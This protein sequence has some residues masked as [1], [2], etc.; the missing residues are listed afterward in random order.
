MTPEQQ[1]I[2][3]IGQ[4]LASGQ[5]ENRA[6]LAD[7]A[8]QFAEVCRSACERLMR[9]SDYLDKGRRSEAAYE[10]R[11][12]P[13]LL[14]L[15][16]LLTSPALKKWH[17]V[18]VDL[19]LT[20]YQLPDAEAIGRLRR[21]CEAEAA[22]EP[23]LREYR[24]LVH[25]SDHAGCIEVLRRIREKDPDNPSW[26]E[27]LRP[28]EEEELPFWVERAERGLAAMD[29]VE[30]KEVFGKLNHPMRV[31]SPPDELMARLRRALL[32]ERAGDLGAEGERTLAAL[33]EAMAAEDV[34]ALERLWAKAAELEADEAFLHR[35]EGWSQALS[36]SHA[37][38]ERLARRR[39][40]QAEF[41]QALSAF[42][43]LLM[44]ESTGLLE[45]RH[46]YERL[47][48]WDIPLPPELPRQ[49]QEVLARKRAARRQRVA[50]VTLAAVALVALLCGVG[51]WLFVRHGRE[52][53]RSAWLA[54][55]EQFRRSSAHEEL[56]HLM[57][58][59][60][61]QD[62][63]FYGAPEL[64]VMRSE[65]EESARRRQQDRRT[66]DSCRDTLEDI[67]QQGF[68][69]EPD[70]IRRTLADAE[71]VASSEEQ[72]AYLRRWK[73]EW[74]TA[75]AAQEA[76]M[77]RRLQPLLDGLQR[78]L[79]DVRTGERQMIA[80]ELEELERLRD[81]C[82]RRLPPAQ[83]AQ[84]GQA[85]RE[86]H[87]RLTGAVDARLAD[88]RRRQAAWEAEERRERQRQEQLAVRLAKLRQDVPA[89]LPNLDRY[90]AL[91]EEFIGKGEGAPE[92]PDYRMV[93]SQFDAY[94]SVLA[95]QGFRMPAQVTDRAA[96]EEAAR[97]LG[98][99]GAAA[100]SVWRLDLERLRQL[101]RT[102]QELQRRMA[103]LYSPRKGIVYVMRLRRHGESQWTYYYG[104]RPFQSQP[105]NGVVYYWGQAYWA[106]DAESRVTLTPTKEL[107]GGADISS[108]NYEVVLSRVRED[109][110]AE[111]VKLARRL[112][113]EASRSDDVAL[114]L[115]DEMSQ[116]RSN[117]ELDP[118]Q[119]LLLFK[120]LV[121]MLS[122]SCADELPE[123]RD[124]AA[125]ASAIQTDVPWQRADHPQ[126]LKAR[127]EIAAFWRS[128]PELSRYRRR[129]EWSRQLL[130][131]VLDT[132]LSCVGSVQPDGKGG[133]GY[134]PCARAQELWQFVP[135][136]Q[137]AMAS[138]RLLPMA[139]GTLAAAGV[140]A[141]GA[142]GVPLF[143]PQP[144]HELRP[145]IE[146][147]RAEDA[148]LYEELPKPQALPQMVP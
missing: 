144:G 22:L 97:L 32:S 1:L 139:G 101:A 40:H 23:L 130:R 19:E 4:L 24:R 54:K 44:T 33:R 74:A 9:C 73:G 28:L 64:T 35:P 136:G 105:D 96:S 75:T 94:R 134:V 114:L 42:R 99:G 15:Y 13:D 89:A 92:T 78:R 120:R 26:R 8:D 87:T 7:Y 55:A 86:A 66:Y 137:G 81:E 117:A 39:E 10:A 50:T 41:A 110:Y 146:R 11:M 12:A 122:E 140:E 128:L 82:L 43:D 34:P 20:M 93:L 29:L 51:A 25:V 103:T 95:L 37:L 60:R 14:E 16:G 5:L 119:G 91:L 27:N 3:Q 143:A 112:T 61:L 131:A 38:A 121:V 106:G 2:Q 47:E 115:L 90:E 79:S 31:V 129:L 127:Q 58:D 147:M 30:L 6:L 85:L 36:D 126:T 56:G 100:S 88:A 138:F 123:S 98:E 67:R 17:N 132:R 57:E 104:E 124:W 45:L 21:E 145:V 70:S 48:G 69:G 59:I 84:A 68:R 65:M 109:N 80:L 116:L 111:H 142:M 49:V 102:N 108:A 83:V 18:C 76:E 148:A 113:A 107:N 141:V 63:V 133:R 46:A 52:T 135:S 125:A 72:K 71:A 118:V 53:R 77:D 62:P